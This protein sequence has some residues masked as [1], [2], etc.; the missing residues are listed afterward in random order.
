M[1]V[2]QVFLALLLLCSPLSVSATEG[3]IVFEIKVIAETTVRSPLSDLISGLDTPLQIPFPGQ[4]EID[5]LKKTGE[6]ATLMFA[7]RLTIGTT[8]SD[9]FLATLSEAGSLSRICGREKA[10][11][12]DA[13][14]SAKPAAHRPENLEE[15]NFISGFESGEFAGVRLDAVNSEIV[16]VD[17]LVS[18]NNQHGSL[19]Q[20]FQSIQLTLGQPLLLVLPSSDGPQK[21]VLISAT[22]ELQQVSCAV[23]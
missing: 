8:Y 15:W 9:T 10:E 16:T 5:V 7:P 3:G 20:S 14:F 17:F 19:D 21:M 4:N 12:L 6:D 18:V 1:R 11:A 13:L 22:R 23:K 2:S